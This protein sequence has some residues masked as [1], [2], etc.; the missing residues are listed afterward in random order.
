MLGCALSVWAEPAWHQVEFNYPVS[1]VAVESDSFAWA[2]GTAGSYLYGFLHWDG[3]NWVLADTVRNQLVYDICFAGA[4]AWAVGEQFN[5][6][7]GVVYRWNGQHW[8]QQPE[9]FDRSLQV[10]AFAD[11]TTGFAGGAAPVTQHPVI[12]YAN[13]AWQID[14][15]LTTR[16]IILGLAATWVGKAYAVGD[17]GAI[18]RCDTGVWT[19]ISSPTTNTLRRVAMESN[20]EGWAVGNAGTIL[21]CFKDMWTQVPSPTTRNLYGLAIA[22]TSCEAW[23]VGDSGTILHCVQ[24][25]WHLEQ[26]VPNPPDV[27]LYTVSFNSG[28][29]GW[30][31]GYRTLGARVALHYYDPLE[32]KESK[33]PVSPGRKGANIVRGVL[34]LSQ[35]TGDKA[36]VTN[37]LFDISGRKVLELHAGVNDIRNLTP[38]VYFIK[39]Q[40]AFISQLSGR[41]AMN[42]AKVV[43]VR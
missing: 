9:P 28:T 24:D 20:T 16:R 42:I 43:V 41:P 18:F 1:A 27:P 15:A 21:C 34:M 14:S 35:S 19:Q 33:V 32:I 3:V 30:A 40:L 7:D 17:S 22:G 10:V 38:G 4:Q 5:F 37:Q 39:E 25:S 6:P 12:K 31:F 13:S 29:H 8:Q 23:A 26:F 11:S 36:P 2:A